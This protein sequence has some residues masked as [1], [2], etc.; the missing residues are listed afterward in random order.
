MTAAGQLARFVVDRSWDE[1]SERARRDL[2]V[3]VLDALGCALGALGAPPVAAVR[4]HV[5][6][7]GGHPL[8]TL[9]GGGATAP[10]RAALYNGA[11]VRYLDLNDSY[12]AAGETCHPSEDLAPVLAAAEYADASGRELLTALA[13]AYQVHC[14]LRR[15]DSLASAPGE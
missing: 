14:R 15:Q 6:E 1:L 7:L 10:D 8:S 12:F 4:A 2:K 5:D 13:V 11:L 3:R 9:I